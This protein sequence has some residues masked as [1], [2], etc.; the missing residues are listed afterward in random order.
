MVKHCNGFTIHLLFDPAEVVPRPGNSSV[1]RSQSGNPFVFKDPTFSSGQAIGAGLFEPA[2][3]QQHTPTG[4]ISR[5]VG[6]H[7][8]GPFASNTWQHPAA[9]PVSGGGS[10]HFQLA[11][12][13]CFTGA[14]PFSTSVPGRT[15]SMEDFLI[16]PRVPDQNRQ[17]SQSAPI[18]PEIPT[19]SHF[20]FPSRK[21]FQFYIPRIKV[22]IYITILMETS[23]QHANYNFKSK[24]SM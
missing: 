2:H 24:L 4:G 10:H 13:S 22:Q 7:L 8:G 19:V 18:V 15:R 21:S 17:M 1:G 5:Q 12:A 6:F 23:F 20:Q 9:C 11:G 3:E 16:E 14:N